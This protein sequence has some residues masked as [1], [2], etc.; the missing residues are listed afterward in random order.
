MSA[1]TTGL[2]DKHNPYFSHPAITA[3]VTTG[4][5]IRQGRYLQHGSLFVENSTVPAF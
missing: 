2:S 1:P 5:D 3:N 4:D